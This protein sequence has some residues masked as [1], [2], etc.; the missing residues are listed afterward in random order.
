MQT[1]FANVL[2][3]QDKIMRQSDDTQ[4]SLVNY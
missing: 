2:L 3:Q 1:G 4:D